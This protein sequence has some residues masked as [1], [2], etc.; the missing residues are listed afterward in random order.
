LALSKDIEY[1]DLSFTTI[2]DAEL[3]PVVSANTRL[4]HLNLS[5]TAIGSE[6]LQKVGALKALRVLAL[7]RCRNLNDV[8]VG[9]LAN[10]P[11]IEILLLT[12]CTGV[13]DAAVSSIARLKTLKSVSIRGTV[14]SAR[15]R[16]SLRRLFGD[17]LSLD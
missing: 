15:G 13:S 9:F 4:S 3:V 12:D 16:K 8:A 5:S 7:A 6:S 2:T 11:V 14:V 17:A 10:L 1:L